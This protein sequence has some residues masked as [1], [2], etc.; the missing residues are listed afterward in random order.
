MLLTP[1]LIPPWGGVVRWRGGRKGFAH[2]ASKIPP[3]PPQGGM[4][5]VEIPTQTTRCSNTGLPC[6]R[7]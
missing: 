4:K 2:I 7:Q 3:C 5:M 6:R 1:A